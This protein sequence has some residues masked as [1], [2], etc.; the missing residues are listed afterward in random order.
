MFYGSH[1]D[2]NRSKTCQLVEMDPEKMEVN[3]MIDITPFV[4]K[5]YKF[6]G[7]TGGY[8]TMEAAVYDHRLERIIF[9][10]RQFSH[11][12]FD[13]ASLNRKGCNK[14]ISIPWGIHET[15]ADLNSM[16]LTSENCTIREFKGKWNPLLGVSAIEWVPGR[17]GCQ[18]IALATTEIEEDGKEIISSHIFSFDLEGNMLLQPTRMENAIKFEGIM[19]IDDELTRLWLSED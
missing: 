1:M 3:Q 18:L 16:K 6:L 2:I 8:L 5:L 9:V 19:P 7:C 15:I 10:P 12:K 13:H 17:E 14:I 4:E 11:S